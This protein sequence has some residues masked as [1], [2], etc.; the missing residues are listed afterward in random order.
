MLTSESLTLKDMKSILSDSNFPHSITNISG[1]IVKKCVFFFI[2][3]FLLSASIFAGETEK[4][5]SELNR[6]M[7]K[8]MITKDF[9]AMLDLYKDDAY[10]LPNFSPMM[11]GKEEFLQAHKEGEKMGIKIQ[12]FELETVDIIDG[13]KLVVE[14]GKYYM[15]WTMNGMPGPMDDEGKYMNV[16][17]MQD[18]GSLKIVVD[19]WN[20][21]T[22][23]MDAMAGAGEHGEEHSGNH[24]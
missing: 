11:H 13:G 3:V 22:N 14:I 18:D 2:C 19:T 12:K 8:L 5:V 24:D 15:T 16:Y 23:P 6:V 21:D 9:N 4:K 1:G 20:A 17:E 7:E 10:S